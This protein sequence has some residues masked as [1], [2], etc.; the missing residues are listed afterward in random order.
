[1]S[2]MN[3]WHLDGSS[4]GNHKVKCPH[5]GEEHDVELPRRNGL[6]LKCGRCKRYFTVHPDG[7]VRR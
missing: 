6:E 2:W 4:M 5:C 1:M 7:N 3:G